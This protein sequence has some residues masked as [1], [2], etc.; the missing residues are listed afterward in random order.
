MPRITQTFTDKGR[1]SSGHK[2]EAYSDDGGKTWLWVSNDSVIM[3]D[4]C[5]THEIPCDVA[6]QTK[7]RE[8]YVHKNVEEYRDRMKN[9]VPTDEEMCEM[10][11]AFGHG[12]TVVNVFTGKQTRL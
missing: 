3:L 10:A 7:A 9:Y 6:A 4:T 1:F 5:K 12:T 8:E 2:A 11:A